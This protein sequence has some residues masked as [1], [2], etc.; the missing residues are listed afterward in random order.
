MT[1]EKVIFF[2]HAETISAHEELRIYSPLTHAG[3]EI[4][5]GVDNNE[6]QIDRIKDAQLVI[7]QRDFSSQF[8]DYI[9]IMTVADKLNKPVVLDMDDNLLN[10]PSNHPDRISFQYAPSLS[11][12]M[13]AMM[14]VDAI[15]VSTSNL[16]K[17]LSFYNPNIFILPNYLSDSFWNFREPRKDSNSSCVNIIF[18]GT[19]THKPDLNIVVDP[20]LAIMKRYG[21]RV[22]VTFWGIEPPEQIEYLDGCHFMPS[23][24]FNYRAFASN[25]TKIDADIAIAPLSDNFFNHC[26]SPIKYFEYTAM[27]LPGI[28]SNLEPYAN[29]IEDSVNGFLAKSE[30]EWE[31]KL[32]LLIEDEVLRRKII[33]QA[34]QNVRDNWLIHN[35]YQLWIDTYETILTQGKRVKNQKPGILPDIESLVIQEG[36]YHKKQSTQKFD[37]QQENKKLIELNEKAQQQNESLQQEN[38][39]LIEL[40]EK[41]QQQNEGLQQE[42]L[43]Y[44]LS[45]SWLIT[46]PLRKLFKIL[47]RG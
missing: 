46:R 40:K 41:V 10:L 23:I 38:Q 16:K 13:H 2:S 21:H 29:V 12:L 44:A 20:L 4:I 14:N 28:F 17:S 15:S 27:G 8:D 36:E 42:I 35:H 33:Y 30:S 5:K 6:L 31:E 19:R 45:D 11:A 9:S 47:R 22:K 18:M 25:S 1:L 43:Y 3:I 39:K 26:K 24:T 32:T 34:Q 37:L 7:F